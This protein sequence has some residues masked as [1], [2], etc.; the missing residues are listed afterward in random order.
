MYEFLVA[1]CC[2]TL[3]MHFLQ[4]LFKQFIFNPINGDVWRCLKSAGG[5]FKL[6]PPPRIISNVLEKG[7]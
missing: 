6:T 4:S 2:F 1:E 5:G 3:N 7:G